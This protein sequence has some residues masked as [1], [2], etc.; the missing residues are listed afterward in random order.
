MAFIG[1]IASRFVPGLSII[2]AQGTAAD[3][4][5]QSLQFSN[6][7]IAIDIRGLRVAIRV[8]DLFQ[9]RIGIDTIQTA[10][11]RIQIQQQPNHKQHPPHL[12]EQRIFIPVPIHLR[13]LQMKNTVL[14]LDGMEIELGELAAN[15]SASVHTINIESVQVDALNIHMLNVTERQS[16]DFEKTL[17]ELKH[18]LAHGPAKLLSD[19]CI[20]LDVKIKQLRLSDVSTRSANQG[21]Q[22]VIDTLTLRAT[23]TESDINISDLR[24]Q[25]PLWHAQAEARAR[26]SGSWPI[27]AKVNIEQARNR[28]TLDLSGALKKELTA[29]LSVQTEQAGTFLAWAKIEAAHDN[30][31]FSLT[32]KNDS[33]KLRHAPDTQALRV[34]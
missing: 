23:T 33:P 27:E 11:T 3:L 28:A 25:T 30:T 14:S 17:Q 7:D 24:L 16:N 4:K 8:A 22:R 19:I 34:S 20:P 15:L 1:H 10:S 13:D 29:S 32:I 26:V 2:G 9:G 6:A 31:P 18:T 21:N 12:R 5:V